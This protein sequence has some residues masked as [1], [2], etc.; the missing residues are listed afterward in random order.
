MQPGSDSFELV[1]NSDLVVN[2]L[3]LKKR[4]RLEEQKRLRDRRKDLLAEVS[5]L[6][7]GTSHRRSRLDEARSNQSQ[8]RGDNQVLNSLTTLAGSGRVGGFHGRLGGLSAIDSKY[9]VAITTA[10]GALN[11]MVCDT[12]EQATQCMDYLRTNKTGRANVMV[13]EKINGQPSDEATPLTRLFDLVKPREPKFA[14]VFWKALGDTLVADNI[15]QANSVAVGGRKRS[16]VVTL[17]GQLVDSS[18]TM[19]GGG[20]PVQRGGMSEKF[21]AQAVS[22]A[23]MSKLERDHQA[24]AAQLQ[25]AQSRLRAAEARVEAL[26]HEGLQLGRQL[27]MLEVDIRDTNNRLEDARK[28]VSKL[29]ARSK[30]DAGDQKWIIE[31]EKEHAQL[32]SS[33]DKLRSKSGAIEAE[34]EALNEKVKAAEGSKLLMQRSKV[35]SIK[36]YIDI[37]TQEVTKAEVGLDKAK[38]DVKRLSSAARGHDQAIKDAKVEV[39]DLAEA[40]EEVREKVVACEEALRDASEWPDGIQDELHGL[41]RDFGEKTEALLAFRKR[42]EKYKQKLEDIEGN[43]A[44]TQALIDADEAKHAKLV[45]EHIDDDED[46]DEEEDGEKKDA[47]ATENIEGDK[48]EKRVKPDPEDQTGSGS[49]SKMNRS[50]DQFQ[51]DERGFVHYPESHL[52][53]RNQ[54][55]LQANIQSLEEHLDKTKPNPAVLKEYRRREL[56]YDDRVKLLDEAT[57]ARDAQKALYNKLSTTR[58]ENFMKGFNNISSKLKEM[59]QMITLGGNAELELVDSMD[60]F[61]EGII[62]RVMPAKKSWRN[63]SNLSGGEKTL[64]SLALVFALQTYKPTPSYFMDE[65]DAALDFRNVSIVANYIKNRTKNA[66]FIIISLRNDMFELSQRLIGIYKTSNQTRSE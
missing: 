10:C 48:T 13:L 33:L 14:K 52:A 17:D 36:K 24:T 19:S 50:K 45:L 37:A 38:K 41:K 61:S 12:V 35:D 20:N 55:S 65:I 29:G 60:P 28:R 18:G 32:L 54:G 7:K 8:G 58:L 15:D 63:I 51:K 49:G 4:S 2:S 21:A 34:I 25:E 47:S 23:E 16:R 11:N 56:E 1:P 26:R 44:A 59:Y 22:P 30:P 9:D 62:F 31:L 64:S 42:E 46:G 6:S 3:K 5:Q 40:S 57:A 43:L 27:Q 66:Q 53:K 39:E